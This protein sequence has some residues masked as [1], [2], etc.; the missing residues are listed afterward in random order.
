MWLE[1]AVEG[2]FRESLG[3]NFMVLLVNDSEY[4]NFTGTQPIPCH[5]GIYFVLLLAR[6]CYSCG[7]FLFLLLLL[8]APHFTPHPFWGGVGTKKR[9]RL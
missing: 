8:R 3:G 4:S 5:R 1:T 6:Y 9:N 7:S 2:G